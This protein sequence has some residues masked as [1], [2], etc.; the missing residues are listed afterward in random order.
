MVSRDGSRNLSQGFTFLFSC[1][2]FSLVI[3]VLHLCILCLLRDLSSW[4]VIVKRISGLLNRLF[5]LWRVDCE[6]NLGLLSYF[7]MIDKIW[8][9]ESSYLDQ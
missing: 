6:G 2:E 7:F 3:V 1:I 4:I 9:S 8:L 5:K